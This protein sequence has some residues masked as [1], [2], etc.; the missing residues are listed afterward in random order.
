MPCEINRTSR[1]FRP[2][3]FQ[4]SRP[5]PARGP[6]SA[7]RGD[8]ESAEKSA[9]TGVEI[10]A[11]CRFSTLLGDH[12]PVTTGV[13]PWFGRGT[14]SLA[15]QCDPPSPRIGLRPEVGGLRPVRTMHSR[16]WSPA[17]AALG[18]V[19]FSEDSRFFPIKIP[20]SRRGGSSH[21]PWG[22]RNPTVKRSSW[23]DADADGNTGP[24][25]DRAADGV[26]HGAKTRSSTA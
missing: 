24:L 2:Q 5:P 20:P 6:R 14:T 18:V 4:N 16:A 19:V 26:G 12:H 11:E 3:D 21:R 7:S 8:A 10:S 13:S 15:R 22:V 9:A 17:S 25:A 23:G 1:D